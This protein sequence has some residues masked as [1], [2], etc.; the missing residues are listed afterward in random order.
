MIQLLR[1]PSLADLALLCVIFHF[2]AG[3]L[4]SN[5]VLFYSHP[6]NGS[7]ITPEFKL[8][9]H[10]RTLKI[11]SETS[12]CG[13]QIPN[14][15][16]SESCD[17]ILLIAWVLNS[18]YAIFYCIIVFHEEY[19]YL[20][21][22]WPAPFT[23]PRKSSKKTFWV[24]S[25]SGHSMKLWIKPDPK[26]LPQSTNVYFTLCFGCIFLNLL[27]FFFSISTFA[28]CVCV[29]AVLIS[30]FIFRVIYLEKES[31]FT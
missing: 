14:F 28:F 3:E 25:I 5:M 10:H 23:M 29:C 17:P 8:S 27:S 24:E 11:S 21:P 13:W 9:H 20:Y 16:L 26:V 1:L 22:E 12:G 6:L 30:L 2:L 31:N 19:T 15:Q 18:A 7:K 4:F